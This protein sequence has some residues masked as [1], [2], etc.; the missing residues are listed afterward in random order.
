ME[1]LIVAMACFALIGLFDD[2]IGNKLGLAD[3]FNQGLAVMGPLSMATLGF[4]C[5]GIS[6]VQ[7][8]AEAIS[9]FTSG[10]PF[11]PSLIIGCILSADVGGL[12]LTLQLAQITTIG[13]YTGALVGGGLGMTVGYQLPVFLSALD[14]KYMPILMRGLVYGLIALPVG[15]FLGGLLL[16]IGI[17]TWLVNTIPVLVLC[18]VL[19]LA[20][21]TVPDGTM[22]LLPVFGIAI[23]ILSYVLFALVIIGIFLPQFAIADRALVEEMMYINVKTTV[24]ACGGLVFC[25]LAIRYCGA[26]IQMV[27]RLLN[28]NAES[29]IGLIINCFQGIAMLPLF[30]KMDRRGKLMNAAFSVCGAYMMGGQMVYVS[31]M[32]DA[33]YMPAYMVNKI[34]SGILAVMLVCLL[35]KALPEEESDLAKEVS[36]NA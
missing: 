9:G 28:T 4:Y 33:T 26:P 35:E 1:F 2:L 29:I 11:D 32:V 25:K 5:I 19:V 13:V 21:F 14:K 12:P 17:G 6:F 3:D 16:D 24:V 10:M 34:A 20:F 7:N 23:R 8:N 18:G 15:L 27:A 30:P 31:S 36:K 22:K